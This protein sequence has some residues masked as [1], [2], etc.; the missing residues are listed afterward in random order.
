[1]EF[2]RFLG[3]GRLIVIYCCSAATTHAT[4]RD[5]FLSRKL[6]IPERPHDSRAPT[7]SVRDRSL[8]AFAPKQHVFV[9]RLYRALAS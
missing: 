2:R 9:I 6:R 8:E 3:P 4:Q 7:S 5:I 1:M